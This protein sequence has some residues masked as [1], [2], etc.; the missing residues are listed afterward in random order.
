V[1][2]S[3]TFLQRVRKIIISDC[4][5]RHV[6]LSVILNSKIEVFSGC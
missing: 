1:V 2:C 6:C 3:V 5:I 4:Y